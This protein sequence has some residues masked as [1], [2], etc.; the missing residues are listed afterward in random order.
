MGVE[1][2]IP[3]EQAIGLIINTFFD[4]SNVLRYLYD[5][6]KYKSSIERDKIQEICTNYSNMFGISVEHSQLNGHKKR[7]QMYVKME[8]ELRIS[9]IDDLNNMLKECQ[10]LAVLYDLPILKD[11]QGNLLIE[12][13]I[14][15]PDSTG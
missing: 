10:S 7:H 11:L 4:F 15:I 14:T 2:K 6:T 1:R 3:K 8:P 5:L 13:T 12:S 9:D